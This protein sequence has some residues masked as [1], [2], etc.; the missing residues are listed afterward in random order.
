[1]LHDVT[2]MLR[3]GMPVWPGEPGIHLKQEKFMARGDAYNIRTLFMGIH[4]G[5]HLDAPEHFLAGG[6]TVESLDVDVLIGPCTVVDV[7]GDPHVSAAELER[8]FPAGRPVPERILFRTRN[9][10]GPS[11]VWTHD[12]FQEGFAA[13]AHDGARWL[14]DRH[15]RLVGVDYL[16]VEPYGAAEPLTHRALLGA[17]M[18]LVEGL[19]LRAIAP[20]RYILHCLPLRLQG[21][22][23]SPARVVLEG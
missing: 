23:G 15:V 11:P 7:P 3:A 1:M 8:L 6:A 13:I 12:D 19:D 4:T 10:T 2:V 16:S 5:T 22:E 21:A 14:A 9:S 20:G 18:I 17:G